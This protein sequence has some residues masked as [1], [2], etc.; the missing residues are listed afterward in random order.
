M[1]LKTQTF[2]IFSFASLAPV[3]SLA[4]NHFWFRLVRVMT[5]AVGCNEP[6]DRHFF[7]KMNVHLAHTQVTV[8]F[9]SA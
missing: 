7:S 8:T 3:A 1:T 5:D 9:C 2:L 6:G 4:F